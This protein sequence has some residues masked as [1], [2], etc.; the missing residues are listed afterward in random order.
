MV[1][2][3][4]VLRSLGTRDEQSIVER[5]RYWIPLMFC[6]PAVCIKEQTTSFIAHLTPHTFTPFLSAHSHHLPKIHYFK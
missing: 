2:F 4:E 5:K 6:E 1:G 3:A